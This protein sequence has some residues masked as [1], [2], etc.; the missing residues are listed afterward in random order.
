MIDLLVLSKGRDAPSTRYRVMQY[1]DR[2][3]L[4]GYR[5][6]HC[7]LAGGIG[8]YVVA[9]RAARHAGLVIVLRK[10]LPAPLLWMLR[11]CARR[12]VFDFDDAIFC[13]TDG[14][15]SVTRMARFRAMAGA[16]DRVLAGNA[17]LA[18]AA[19]QFNACVD[20]I[21]TAV[22]VDR[23]Q[24]RF[25]KPTDHFDVVWIGSKS[26]RKYL[27]MAVPVL[28]EAIKRI[29]RLRLKIIA[30]FA[31]EVPG[32]PTISI[33]WSAECEAAELAASHVGIAPMNENDWTRG[34]CA[35]KVLQ[36]MAAGLSVV[37]SPVGVNGEAVLPGQTGYLPGS[38]NEWVDALATLAWDPAR[39]RLLGEAG[40]RRV[41]S[42]YSQGRVFAGLEASLAAT[43]GGAVR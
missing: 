33:P 12:L 32:V 9:L 14:S 23:Y 17:F 22:D 40:R 31:F 19:R 18:T 34:K 4:A 21:P 16:C 39:A 7:E 43:L 15:A 10:T 30:D 5:V 2:L 28:R 27:E 42:V 1:L 36:Y 3:A 11:R 38:E 13:N 37:S 25:D 8:Q 20:V 6:K 35:L 41:E 26:T 29:P 24:P